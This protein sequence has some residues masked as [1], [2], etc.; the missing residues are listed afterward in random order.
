MT[1]AQYGTIAALDYNTLVGGDPVT[2]TGKLNSV[3]ATGGTESGY[4]QTA[5]ANV[6]AGTTVTAAKWAALV[7]NTAN[8]GSHQGSSLSSVTTPAAGGTIAYQANIPTNLTTIYTNRLN[9]ASQSSTSA[10]SVNAAAFSNVATFTHTATFANG[11]AARYFFNCGGQFKLT[12]AHPTGGAGDNMLNVLASD[13]GT[14]VL[15]APAS[16]TATIAGTTYNGV[17]KVGGANVANTTITATNGY[18]ALTT[19]NV[20]VFTQLASTGP[21]SYIGNTFIRVLLKTNGTVGSNG[22]HG[23]VVTLYTIWDEVPNGISMLANTQTTLTCVPPEVAN[24]ANTWGTITLAG[25]V[26]SV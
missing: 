3:W 22:D 17:T 2:G 13:A 25:S 15:S 18:Y 20:N 1:Y 24:I 4:G 11:D 8:C 26:A 9:A 5:A 7:S 6:T 12:F 14:V 10:N 16:G 19:S 23:N 21:A